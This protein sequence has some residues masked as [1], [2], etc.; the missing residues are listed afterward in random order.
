[1]TTAS[2]VDSTSLKDSTALKRRVLRTIMS[3]ENV[4]Q[5][6]CAA[7]YARLALRYLR[8]DTRAEISF[9]AALHRRSIMF[10][11]EKRKTLSSE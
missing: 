4:G 9:K 10:E 11:T 5:L 3:C 2:L 1:M 7:R 6:L 8:T